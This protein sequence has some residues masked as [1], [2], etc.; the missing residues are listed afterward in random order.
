MGEKKVEAVTDGKAVDFCTN[1]GLEELDQFPNDLVIAKNGRVYMSG[2]NWATNTGSIWTCTQGTAKFM[3]ESTFATNGITLSP[4]EK[5]LY[6][7]R[8]ARPDWVKESIQK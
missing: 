8:S 6:F 3:V 1:L 2:M 4:D 7:S 5:T